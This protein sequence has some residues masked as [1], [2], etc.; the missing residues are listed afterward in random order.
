VAETPEEHERDAE[1]ERP[2][3]FEI[4]LPP[5]LESGVYANFLG[6]WHTAHEFTLDFAQVQPAQMDDPE[7]PAST[8]TLPARV[9]A[10]VKIP[11][12]VVFDVIR[13]LNE[14]MTRYEQA[15][16]EIRRPGS[17]D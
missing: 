1:P 3:N 7:D 10:R 14:N 17:E 2:A 5:E 15:F 6:V 13:A 8:V 9:V 16:G 12:T 11:V 4:Q